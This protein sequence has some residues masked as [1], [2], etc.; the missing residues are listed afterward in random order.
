MT[1]PHKFVCTADTPWSPEKGKYAVHPDAEI[2]ESTCD[3]C[4]AYRCPH[5]GEEFNVELPE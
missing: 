5:C 3:C 2:T 4:E 1:P